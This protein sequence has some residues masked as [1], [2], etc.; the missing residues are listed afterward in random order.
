MM[1]YDGTLQPDL[2]RANVTVGMVYF[3]SIPSL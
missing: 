2:F 3:Q 1:T